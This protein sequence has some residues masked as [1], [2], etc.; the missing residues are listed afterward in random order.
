ME[1]YA[2]GKGKGFNTEQP[3]LLVAVDNEEDEDSQAFLVADRK[4]V[5]EVE[6]TSYIYCL[7]ILMAFHYAL[8]IAYKNS[9]NL[10]YKFIE[11]FFPEIT[12]KKIKIT[13]NS[14]KRFLRWNRKSERLR[15][16]GFRVAA[17][18]KPWGFA[19]NSKLQWVKPIWGEK[20]ECQPVIVRRYNS[21]KNWLF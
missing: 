14:C 17:K 9:Q 4:V 2:K 12:P 3:W 20:K 18:T 7:F 15:L 5:C 19:G 6:P 21:T 16:K 11:E 8:N 1:A 13:E 10:L